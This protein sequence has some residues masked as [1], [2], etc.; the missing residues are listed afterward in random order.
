MPSLQGKTLVITGASRGIG[1]AIAIRAARDGANIAVL[2]KTETPHPHL[3]GTIHEV[4]VEV[5]AAGGRALAIATDVRFED[6]VERAI[7]R[8][9]A[10][11]GQIDVLV[12]NAGAIA[13]LGTQAT[14]LKQFDL[15]H[16]VNVRATFLCTQ[17][18]L[19]QLLRAQ[20]PHV[21]TM[22]PPLNLAAQWFRNHVAYTISKYAMSMCVLGMAEE[23]ADRGVAFN[24]LWPRTIIATAAIERLGGEQMVS[25]ARTPD[26]VADAAHAILI[27]K[28]SECTGNF[29]MD[30][31]VLRATGLSDFS[32][33]AF[34][35]GAGDLVPDLFVDS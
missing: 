9:V 15:M 11:F 23:F 33:Y 28:A 24:A 35:P 22:S 30:E 25:R 20:N 29:F 6:Q 32:R 18:C 21:L 31:D 2:G 13:L 17:K 16:D 1:R 12:N 3:S 4:V 5:E 26:I 8:T 14:S 27:R 34:A 19:P 7:E 10:E